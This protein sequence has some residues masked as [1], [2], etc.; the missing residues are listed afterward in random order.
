VGHTFSAN[1]EESPLQTGLDKPKTEY[2][3]RSAYVTNQWNPT[4]LIGFRQLDLLVVRFY[5]VMNNM[6]MPAFAVSIAEI[7]LGHLASN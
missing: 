6:R 7:P 5:K 2:I 3:R 4:E 1:D